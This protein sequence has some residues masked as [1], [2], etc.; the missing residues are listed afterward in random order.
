MTR[1]KRLQVTIFFATILMTSA[2]VMAEQQTITFEM[3]DSAHTVTFPMTAKELKAQNKYQSQ[4]QAIIERD[5][6][7]VAP[8][9]GYEVIEIG[10]GAYTIAYPRTEKNLQEY[11]KYQKEV[12]VIVE[13]NKR[14]KKFM[15]DI[16]V[17]E[18][19]D[20]HTVTF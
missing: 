3:G 19:A 6:K 17:M 18:M 15:V 8:E 16:K 2:F 10:D 20:G 9:D 11:K 13:R 14:N 5:K 7:S 4:I 1:I 12:G